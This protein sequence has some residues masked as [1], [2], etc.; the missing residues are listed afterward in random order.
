MRSP[1]HAGTA[2]VLAGSLLLMLATA[3]PASADTDHEILFFHETTGFR[4]DSIE[5]ALE[6]V[7]ALGAEHGFG[8]TETQESEEVFTD[9]GLAA[10]DAVVFFTDGEGTLNEDE[11]AAFERFVNDG[12]GVVGLHSA[13]NMDT[14]D[15]PWW[16][17]LMGGAFFTNHPSGDD[18]FQT[19]TMHV[20]EQ[21]HPSTAHLDETWEWEE[22][23]YNF[24]ANPRDAGVHVLM[25]V[26]EDTYTGGEM[27]DDHPVAWCSEFDGGRTFY[28]ALG[29]ES[30]YYDDSDFQ[31]H[32]LGGIQ[33]ATGAE[34]GE[35]GE[36]RD[37]A[38]GEAAFERV[39][40]DDN[41]AN[42]MK[43]DIA[44][45]GRVF[46]TELGGALKIHHPDDQSVTVAAEL[47]VYRQ[48]ENGLV[49]VALDPDFD[50]NQWLYLFYTDPEMDTVD[51][52]DGGVQ[53]VSRFTFDDATQQL[54]LASEEILL[55]IPHQRQ[56]CCHTAGDIK[57]GPDGALLITTGDDTN[58]FGSSG[59][60]PID[61]RDGRAPWDAARTSGNTADLR[62]KVL[63]I[64]PLDDPGG[65]PGLGNTYTVP[66]DNLFTEANDTWHHLF[67]GGSFDPELG[68]PEIY[69]MGVRNPFGMAV[70]QVS[71]EVWVGE[72]GPDSNPS[73]GHDENRGPRGYDG[74]NR[75]TEATNFGWPFCTGD[76]EAY[77]QWD[78]ATQTPGDF[79][80]CDDGPVNDSPNNTGLDQLP[81]AQ[82]P[83]IWYPYCPYTADPPFPEIP[84][85]DVEG[86]Q[87]Y[88]CGRAAYMGD[89]Y[90]YDDAN[91]D[92]EAFP[93]SF[94]G[95]PFLLEWERDVIATIDR[96]DAG[97][98]V[99]G[100]FTEFMPE[101]R[102]DDDQ[103]FRKPHDMK[104]GP[105]GQMYL[106]EW[107]DEFNFGG[108]GVNPDS[109]LYRIS[110]T[111]EGRTPIARAEADPDNGPLPLDVE[112]SSAGS[113]D[114]DGGSL[115]Y[116]W[117]FG[118]GT[119]STEP[120]PEHTFTDAGAYTVQL[121]VTNEG[122]RS[123]SSNVTVTAGNT[124]P[125]VTIEFP[126]HGGFTEWGDE[127]P[128]EVSVVDAEDGSIEDGSLD[129]SDVTIDLGLWHDPGEG[130]H[131]HPGPSLDGCAG[132][133]EIQDE[134]DHGPGHDIAQVV[135]ASYTD[136]GGE[137]GT[138]PLTGGTS[139]YLHPKRQLARFY[140][141]SSGDPTVVSVDDPENPYTA[142]A[143]LSD[144]DWVSY[145][146][147]DLHQANPLAF[148]VASAG[149]GEIE[150][151]E[152]AADGPVLGTVD[153]PDTG[154]RL[155]WTT[156]AT[157]VEDPGGTVELVLVA[158]GDNP[159][160]VGFY[161]AFGQG[162]SAEARPWVHLT[163]P[164]P[165]QDHEIGSDITV[166]AEAH[167]PNSTIRSVEFFADG[168]P[169]GTVNG[170]RGNGRQPF[171]ITWEDV[172]EGLYDV[173]AVVTNRH[174][175]STESHV[176]R[177][178]VGEERSV[179]DDFAGDSLDEIRWDRLV[180]PDHD[181]MGVSDGQLHLET[182]TGDIFGDA[183]DM[184]NIVLQNSPEGDWAIQTRMHAPL[185]RNYQNAG[186]MVYDDDD[187]YLKFG[188]VVT[189]EPTEPRSVSV[190]AAP[191]VDGSPTVF[192]EPA[193]TEVNDWWLRMTRSGDSYT[194]DWSTD[195]EEW[196][197]MSEVPEIELGAPAFGVY[198]T[199]SG[200][201]GE[202]ES[203]TVSWDCFELIDEGEEVCA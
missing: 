125:E 55:E 120:D 121:T 178:F 97:D 131:V 203:V 118:D 179:S 78:F 38:P 32:I 36:P 187:N 25:T 184:P 142:L 180:R 37:S 183:N 81:A 105:D 104:F 162:V 88:G 31:Q 57:F 110:Y 60:A 73:G 151:R 23:W 94:D 14:T 141:D 17:D 146:P 27:G 111:E 89:F 70:D 41:T 109:G 15:W 92:T 44:S 177:V 172:D 99:A 65:E 196:N 50:E 154:G 35:C 71:G 79:Y 64:V 52:T 42:P 181:L 161:E 49:G 155:D 144:G 147:V 12:G 54:D 153:V 72:V 2:S 133:I 87:N 108:G 3:P 166:T 96:D 75:I 170:N 113:T 83:E 20:E 48:H 5:T 22:E 28:T 7:E 189:S 10:F 112:F 199:G 43:L 194:L 11:R 157:E 74:W 163:E 8:V 39:A 51:G 58:P 149:G 59:F 18:Q 62:G 136:S 168:E 174:D 86:G 138:P 80:A 176:Q 190:E 53:H 188:F 201:Q 1:Q 114:P 150:I 169:I 90:E 100:S 192:N 202:N 137:A 191:E 164:L 124:R 4:H 173:T 82:P 103:R 193:P 140:E 122:G 84:S 132:M 171:S 167:A 197:T 107:G 175:E 165:G 9:D 34:D 102:F 19:A 85:G 13:S 195:G 77:R 160:S 130:E 126:G 143:D 134:A 45:D 24:A 148:R 16:E 98:Y 106:I 159:V 156:V 117:D 56:E 67:P 63:R 91:A 116:A 152:G 66:D 182:T 93:A 21:G 101:H 33:W 76:N 145:H 123:S 186:L 95:T 115:E 68:Y 139:H 40:L 200:L 128:Y 61:Y 30:H 127:V 46:Y 119:T 129:C 135:T 29:H 6:T 198:A 26:D 158:G 185:I 69:A 47:D